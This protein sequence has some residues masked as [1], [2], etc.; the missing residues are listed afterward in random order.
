MIRF[1]TPA[2]PRSYFQHSRCRAR[3]SGASATALPLSSSCSVK[4]L[5]SQDEDSDITLSPVR[6]DLVS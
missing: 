3:R 6:G 1:P 4:P 2:P 5:I